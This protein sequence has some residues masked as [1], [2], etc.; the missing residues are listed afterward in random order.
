[1][2]RN[3]L[4]RFRGILIARQTELER[5]VRNREALA[6]GT[7]HDELDRVQQATEREMAIDN[8]ER[9]SDRLR[10]VQS[11]LRRIDAGT[12]WDLPRLRRIYQFEA[13]RSS[14]VERLVYHLP[15]NGGSQPQPAVECDR[16]SIRPRG[17]TLACGLSNSHQPV[18]T[19]RESLD[20]Y[21]CAAL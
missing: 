14:T 8:L 12:F 13:T 20:G 19:R 6:I 17:I 18:Q 3:E 2:T 1:M 10:E 4:K 5:S 15:R 21:G 16:G 9:Q 11:A 7:S